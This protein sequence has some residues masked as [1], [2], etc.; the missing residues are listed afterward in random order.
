VIDISATSNSVFA[1][2]RLN[3]S[4]G[5]RTGIGI[6]LAPSTPISPVRIGSSRSYGRHAN[7]IV[8][9]ST[10]HALQ[11]ESMKQ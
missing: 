4:T 9:L 6:T 10:R 5:R 7:E 8:R 1:S 11:P 2:I 3:S